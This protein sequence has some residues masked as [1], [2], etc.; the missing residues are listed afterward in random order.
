MMSC[1]IEV[2]HFQCILLFFIS[3][4]RLQLKEGDSPEAKLDCGL[5]KGHAYTITDIRRVCKTI[6]SICV[7][8]LICTFV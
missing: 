2:C 7:C 1:S 5:V 6:A 3:S 8:V 4:D